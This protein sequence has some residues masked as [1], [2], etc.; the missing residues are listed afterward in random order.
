[1][2]ARPRSSRDRE[3]DHFATPSA[4]WSDAHFVIDAVVYWRGAPGLLTPARARVLGND[5]IPSTVGRRERILVP[6]FAAGRW[7]IRDSVF[8]GERRILCGPNTYLG[9]QSDKKSAATPSKG[10]SDNS[11]RVPHL[12]S[13]L[14][15]RV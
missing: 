1:M 7:L 3:R 15:T 14:L 10:L 6:C 8:S 5:L 4:L 12:V 2:V 9:Q 11:H 13:A